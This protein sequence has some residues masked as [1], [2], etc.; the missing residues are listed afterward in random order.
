MGM[1][2]A[3]STSAS[4]LKG[5]CMH[6]LDGSYGCRSGGKL[7]GMGECGNA[8]GAHPDDKEAIVIALQEAN[9]MPEK[10]IIVSE[11]FNSAMIPSQPGWSAGG[12]KGAGRGGGKGGK[13]GGR[14]GGKGGN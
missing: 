10:P 13:N 11:F 14:G 5:I 9:G 3:A 2:R 12:G 7:G 6:C 8:H 1:Q 4:P